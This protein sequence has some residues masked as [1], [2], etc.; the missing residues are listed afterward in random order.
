LPIRTLLAAFGSIFLVGCYSFAKPFEIALPGENGPNLKYREKLVK[1]CGLA[2]KQF[3]NVQIT[4][5]RDG[6]WRGNTRGLGVRWLDGEPC[7]EAPEERC[8]TG[9]LEPSCG[10]ETFDNHEEDYDDLICLS[11]GHGFQWRINQVTKARD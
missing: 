1:V 6:N 7:T 2:T 5:H 4:E 9:F 10:W 3:E 8:V 11:T